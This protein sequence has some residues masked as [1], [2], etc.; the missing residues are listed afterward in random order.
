[1]CAYWKINMA[2]EVS[3]FL[4]A[5]S[6]TLV[7]CQQGGCIGPAPC[8]YYVYVCPGPV[9]QFWCDNYA[10][11]PWPAKVQGAGATNFT[12]IGN[13]ITSNPASGTNKNQ[14][15]GSCNDNSNIKYYAENACN[16]PDGKVGPGG[17]NC[18]Y[19]C[20]IV[21]PTYSTAKRADTTAGTAATTPAP[22]PKVADCTCTKGS[23]ISCSKLFESCRNNDGMMAPSCTDSQGTCKSR[24]DAAACKAMC[25][26]AGYTLAEGGVGAAPSS[27]STCFPANAEL[28]LKDGSAIRMD[29]LQVGHKVR[30]SHKEHSEVF[31]FSTKYT[32]A[33]ATFVHL[34]TATAGSIQLTEG[35]Y[36]YVNGKV[37]QASTVK[38]G[39]LLETA[40]GASAT[41]TGIT[42]V[43][44]TG[45]YNPHTMQGDIIV[46]GFRTTTYTEAIHPTLAHAMLAPIR[47]LYAMNVTVA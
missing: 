42:T 19:S 9:D 32:D 23:T 7:S 6:V 8:P 45:L 20:D 31:M 35:H 12:C 4:L 29:T 28:Q 3:F 26:S 47:A 37:A 25:L 2:I 38:V 10:G 5:V 21:P 46:N 34:H 14:C 22:P 27:S 16:L 11:P 18:Y 41:V 40:T 30:V 15:S 17:M 44:A 1:M 36:L 13:V 24:F 33:Q 43:Q 39:D